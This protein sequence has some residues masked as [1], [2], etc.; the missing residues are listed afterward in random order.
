MLNLNASHSKA[1]NF[2]KMRKTVT[3]SEEIPL[4]FSVEMTKGQDGILV[5]AGFVKKRLFFISRMMTFLSWIDAVS[6][7]QKEVQKVS[8]LRIITVSEKTLLFVLILNPFC[9]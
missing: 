5:Q 7:S 2:K 8:F 4:N 9:F 6:N 1:E 3:F